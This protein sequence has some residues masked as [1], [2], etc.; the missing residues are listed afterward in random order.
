MIESNGGGDCEEPRGTLFFCS[1]EPE[2]HAA[3]IAKLKE[4]WCSSSDATRE[5]RV[6][7]LDPRLLRRFDMVDDCC[8]VVVCH[9]F[10]GRTL[11]TDRDGLYNALLAAATRASRGNVFVALAGV[12]GTARHEIASDDIVRQL[13]DD[14]GQVSIRAFHRHRRFL[15]WSDEPSDR[16]VAHVAGQGEEWVAPIVDLPPSLRAEGASSS[17]ATR[18]RADSRAGGGGAFRCAL[19]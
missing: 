3:A 14:G 11:L 4:R 7:R 12:D 2:D 17:N 5:F 16:Q 1:L 19:L 18:S 8:A 13:A 15:T 9:L 6:L 10:D